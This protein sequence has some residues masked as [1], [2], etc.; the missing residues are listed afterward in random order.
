MNND[1]TYNNKITVEEYYV[2]RESAGWF[3]PENS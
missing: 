1:I 3:L 2:M